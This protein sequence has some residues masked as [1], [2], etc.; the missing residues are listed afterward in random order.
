MRCP[1]C[2]AAEVEVQETTECTRI[3]CRLC[4]NVQPHPDVACICKSGP[5]TPAP[6]FE[7]CRVS[8]AQIRAR[9]RKDSM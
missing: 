9:M 4:G 3:V 5:V 6:R 8:A 7:C 1:S 2:N